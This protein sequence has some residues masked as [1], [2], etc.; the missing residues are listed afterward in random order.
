MCIS[1]VD[2]IKR[3]LHGYNSMAAS[4][5][6]GDCLYV[7]EGTDNEF[8]GLAGSSSNSPSWW[9]LIS[10]GGLMLLDVLIREVHKKWRDLFDKGQNL[11]GL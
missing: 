4:I 11:R 10:Q 6:S 5:E 1:M 3:D 7:W 8:H 2:H 9:G